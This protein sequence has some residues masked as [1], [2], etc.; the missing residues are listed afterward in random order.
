MSGKICEERFELRIGT[1]AGEGCGEEPGVV[2]RCDCNALVGSSLLSSRHCIRIPHLKALE[3]SLNS[4][5]AHTKF[6][7]GVSTFED[8]EL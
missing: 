4:I 1:G 6:C 8:N 2:L 7:L 3:N 5:P